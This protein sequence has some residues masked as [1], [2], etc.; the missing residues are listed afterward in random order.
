M[1]RKSTVILGVCFIILGVFLIFS[2]YWRPFRITITWPAILIILGAAMLVAY[3]MYKPKAGYLK[4][5]NI[6]LWL[7]LYFALIHDILHRQDDYGRLW[8]GIIIVIGLALISTAVMSAAHR[9]LLG[10]GLVVVTIGVVLQALTL[11]GWHHFGENEAVLIA[12]LVLIAI[13]VKLVIDFV[14]RAWG[15]EKA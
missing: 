13:G 8:P 10:S 1:D 5:G 4:G 12:G 9:K 3:F 14:L 2:E 7:G 15:E 11:Y 6:L